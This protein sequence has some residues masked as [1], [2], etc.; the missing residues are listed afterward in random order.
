MGLQSVRAA[1]SIS[2]EVSLSVDVFF[3]D[4]TGGACGLSFLRP[5]S[6]RVPSSVSG[7][8]KTGLRLC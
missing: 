2:G 7:V 8:T 5:T 6:G 3:S 4:Q 1:L